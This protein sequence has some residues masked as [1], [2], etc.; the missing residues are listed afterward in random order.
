MLPSWPELLILCLRFKDYR[1]TPPHPTKS[2]S[3]EGF[4]LFYFTL[5]LEFCFDCLQ[6]LPAC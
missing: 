4:A 1:C 5:F 6:V 3:V 2:D